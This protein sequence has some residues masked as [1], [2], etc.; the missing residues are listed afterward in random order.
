MEGN[1]FRSNGKN[2]YDII[3][4]RDKAEIFVV[5]EKSGINYTLIGLLVLVYVLVFIFIKKLKKRK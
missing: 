5:T 4:D 3:L 1:L 2:Q